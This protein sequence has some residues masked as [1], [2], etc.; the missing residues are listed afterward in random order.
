MTSLALGALDS[1]R[2][3]AREGDLDVGCAE[4]GLRRR[5]GVARHRQCLQ[6]P[7]LE[8]H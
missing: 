5:G 7:A 3:H 8:L 2:H 1:G 6:Q 4:K